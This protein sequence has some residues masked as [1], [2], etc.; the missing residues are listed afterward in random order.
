MFFLINLMS[1]YLKIFFFLLCLL[2]FSVRAGLF[3]AD[4]FYLSNGIRG[5]VVQNNK[6]PIVQFMVWYKVGSID[7]A[8]GKGGLA[9]LLEHLM[10]RGTTKVAHARF[11]DIVAQN[12]GDSNAFT[13]HDFTAYHTLIDVSRLETLMALEAD[14]LKNLK[15]TDEAFEAERA[16]VAQ[17]RRQRILNNPV[18]VFA[19]DLDRMFWQGEG[20]GRPISGTEAEIRS[21]TQKDAAL[22]YHKFYRP[23]NVLLVF[24]GN[25]TSDEAKTLAEKYFGAIQT[26]SPTDVE[27][28]KVRFASKSVMRLERE[29]ASVNTPR[30]IKKMMA[31]SLKENPKDAYALLL[32]TDYLDSGD[33]SYLNK[34]LVLSDKVTAV[35]ASYNP[36][37]R[38]KGSFSIAAVLHPDQT[39]AQTEAVIHETLLNALDALSEK[40]LEKEKQKIEAGLVYVRDDPTDAAYWMGQLGAL[41]IK[42]EDIENYVEN[43]KA[44]QVED[45]RAAVLNMFEN[46][47]QIT[48]LLLPKSSKREEVQ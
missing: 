16:I 9:H 23:D 27:P 8:A 34:H 33:N 12:G 37:S 45:V 6:A 24:S 20:Y 41:G 10:F 28:E 29:D 17:E 40:D 30:F 2:P 26:F 46:S 14:R 5:L 47:T 11:N 43:L 18:T 25:I 21:L 38:L 35:S 48:G 31:P 32:F 15:I 4:E 19:E 13:S 39:P 7:E 44:V 22:F 42:L 3:D 36:F 1:R